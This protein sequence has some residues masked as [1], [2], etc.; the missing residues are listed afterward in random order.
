[1]KTIIRRMLAVIRGFLRPSLKC[2]TADDFLPTKSN[3][4]LG[5][6]ELER[7]IYW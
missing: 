5:R 6:Q 4:D 7:F 1:M 3:Q 2:Q